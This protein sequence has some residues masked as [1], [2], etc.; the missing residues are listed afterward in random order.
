[1]VLGKFLISQKGT[2]FSNYSFE[3][4]DNWVMEQSIM[5]LSHLL[6][7]VYPTLFKLLLENFIALLMMVIFKKFGKKKNNIWVTQFCV[8]K[9]KMEYYG[10]G[11]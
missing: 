2:Q 1:M 5:H 3:L 7:P 6:F 9:K 10:H 11:D 4:E 8:F